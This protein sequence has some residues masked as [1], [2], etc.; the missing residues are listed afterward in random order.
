M[1]RRIDVKLRKSQLIEFNKLSKAKYKHIYV[2]IYVYVY[3]NDKAIT[4]NTKKKDNR[5][6]DIILQIKYRN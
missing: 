6:S 1:T 4:I 5:Y 2:Y 3:M